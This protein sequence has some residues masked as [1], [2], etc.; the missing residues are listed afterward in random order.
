V[1]VPFFGRP[2]STS[3]ALAV[4]ALRTGTPIVPIFA[5]RESRGGHR[6][7]IWPPLELPVP[8]DREEATV[9]LTARCTAAI[10]AAI[11]QAPEQWLWMHVRWR[12]RQEV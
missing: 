3:R 12:T 4:L 2:A 1:F 6:V 10:E 5:R 9:E 7:I 11:R 8:N